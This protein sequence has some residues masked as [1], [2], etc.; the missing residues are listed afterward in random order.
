MSSVIDTS[1]EQPSCEGWFVYLIRNRMGAL[2]CGV[3][4][5]LCR[6]LSQHS[7][8]KGAKSLRGKGPL[9][10]VW[11]QNVT[12]KSC[13]LKHEYAIK[14]LSKPLKERLVAEQSV[15]ILSAHT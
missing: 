9:T 14:Q 8:G 10:L 15:H 4:N 6:R 11:Y 3:T 5:D 1:V 7:S 2:Y 13:A 12:S